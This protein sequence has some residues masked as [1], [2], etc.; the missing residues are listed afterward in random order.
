MGALGLGV[1]WDWASTDAEV[2][3]RLVIFLEDRRVLDYRSGC[4][5]VGHA[6]ASVLQVREELTKALQALAPKSGANEAVRALREACVA[7]LDSVDGASGCGCSGK[8]AVPLWELQASF[9]AYLRPL[10]DNYHLSAH[11]SVAEVLSIPDY[12]RHGAL[13]GAPLRPDGPLA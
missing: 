8:F 10:V 3:R 12:V 11:G 6:V 5:D 9:G 2:V 4:W 1:G 13:P 7:F